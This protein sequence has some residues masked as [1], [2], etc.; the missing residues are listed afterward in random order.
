MLQTSITI[1]GKSTA[2]DFFKRQLLL[3][4]RIL[5]R[6]ATWQ[7]VESYFKKIIAT[8][9]EQYFLYSNHRYQKIDSGVSNFNVPLFP[10]LL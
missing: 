2:M 7:Q 3:D 1:D 5:N 10:Q 4:L 9:S 8:R 6:Q